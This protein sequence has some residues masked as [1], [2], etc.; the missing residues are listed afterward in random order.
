MPQGIKN[1]VPED[2]TAYTE[3]TRLEEKLEEVLD[4][5]VKVYVSLLNRRKFH[6]ILSDNVESSLRMI[7][8][9]SMPRAKSLQ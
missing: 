4:E 9:I 3:R 8:I 5:K 1:E 7:D 2:F 6:Q